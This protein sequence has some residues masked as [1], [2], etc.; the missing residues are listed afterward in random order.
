MRL[1]DDGLDDGAFETVEYASEYSESDEI[2]SQLI[3]VFLS[4]R[5]LAFTYLTFINFIH[6]TYNKIMSVICDVYF[7]ISNAVVATILIRLF[8]IYCLLHSVIYNYQRRYGLYLIGAWKMGYISFSIILCNCA[9]GNS[10]ITEFILHTIRRG[11]FT[12]TVFAYKPALAEEISTFG[13][14]VLVRGSNNLV[15]EEAERSLHGALY[16]GLPLVVER[17]LIPSGGAAAETQLS[18]PLT[19]YAQ[20]LGGLQ[21]CCVKE[22]VPYTLAENDGLNPIK[23]VTKLRKAHAATM[24]N[25]VAAIC[26]ATGDIRTGDMGSRGDGTCVIGEILTR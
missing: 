20:S 23:I 17:Y 14:S 3:G 8:I 7:I 22:V 2:I 12:S 15:L 26:L 10:K 9:I 5:F 24:D 1:D 11:I 18:V 16:V 6:Y 13:V 19:K 4:F 25:D 21:S